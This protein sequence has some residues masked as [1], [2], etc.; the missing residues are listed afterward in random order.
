MS[1]RRPPHEAEPHLQ[2]IATETKNPIPEVNKMDDQSYSSHDCRAA[3]VCVYIYIY[4]KKI[5]E[6]KKKTD[7]RLKN[8]TKPK[9]NPIKKFKKRPINNIF[10]DL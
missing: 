2:V 6:N 7:R 8:Q 9:S 1:K 5:L 10:Y 4:M 3:S